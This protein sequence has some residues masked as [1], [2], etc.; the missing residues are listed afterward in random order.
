MTALTQKILEWQSF[1]QG[2]G[3]LGVL[4]YALV[5]V[6]AQLLCAPLSPVAVAGGLIFGL[7]RGFAAITL[8]TGLG[9]V[10]NFLLSRHFARA[11]IQRW[12]A[13]H[14]K[15]KLIDA[16]IGR[17]GWKI[18]ALLRFCPIPFGL[19]NYCYGLT[20]VRFGPYL[21]ATIFAVMPANF[22]FSWFGASSHDA[23]A[24][25]GGT[26]QAAQPGRWVFTVVGL[27]AFFCALTYV[28]KIARAAVQRSGA[29]EG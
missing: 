12:L 25:V 2:L 18:I 27:V 16:A 28:A 5:I 19:A 1:F 23:L 15:F 26:G 29:G 7:G 10:V 8:G 20:A 4:T 21:V 22:F 17:E 11:T 13:H 9:A 14:E 6:A 24:A 3:W